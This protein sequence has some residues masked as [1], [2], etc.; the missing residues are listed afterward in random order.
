MKHSCLTLL[1]SIGILLHSCNSD[2]NVG[3]SN[4]ECR[5]SKY[6]QV[7]INLQEVDYLTYLIYNNNQIHIRKNF[8]NLVNP[9]TGLSVYGFHSEDEIFYD[10]QN[11]VSKI[12]YDYNRANGTYEYDL[13]FYEGNNKEPN[14]RDRVKTNSNGTSYTWHELITYDSQNR[15]TNTITYWENDEFASESNSFEYKDGNLK[16]YTK[17]YMNYTDG[18]IYEQ[19]V[20]EYSDYDNMKNPFQLIEA[21]FVEDRIEKYSQ[22]NY[23]KYKY[24]Q[25]V[26]KSQHSNT[27]EWQISGYEYDE[28]GYPLNVEFLCK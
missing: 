6:R 8:V 25:T 20:Y 13:F 2:D 7:N 12:V 18:E 23:R 17:S 28:N 1:I 14:K 26:P 11:R 16:K 4:V 10:S 27:G 15:I 3:A 19:W 22:N 5:I 9:A 24:I 21:P